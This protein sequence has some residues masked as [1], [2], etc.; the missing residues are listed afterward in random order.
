MAKKILIADDDDN[1]RR[2]VKMTFMDE[3]FEIHEASDGDEAINKAREVKPDLVILDVMM[4]KK[5][6]Y[7]V[8]EEIKND[9]ETEHAYVIFI[10]AR[11]T[12]VAEKAGESSGGDDFMVKPFEPAELRERVKKA[13]GAE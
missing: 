8:C 13:L 12:S 3:G 2:L 10:T 9:P 4:P 11:G 7:E 6:G 5:V 1:I